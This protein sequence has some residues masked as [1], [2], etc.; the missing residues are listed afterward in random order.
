MEWQQFDE[1]DGEPAQAPRH[2]TAIFSG[3][4]QVVYG[5]VP[6]CTQVIL[7]GDFKIYLY[8]P[9]TLVQELWKW[10]LCVYV[11]ARVC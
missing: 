9:P 8:L 7:I 1:G 3:S 6:N 11:Y 10:S 5:F 4:R 2:L